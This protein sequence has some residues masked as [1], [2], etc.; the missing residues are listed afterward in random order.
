MNQ[1]LGSMMDFVMISIIIRL[2]TMMVE[3]AVDVL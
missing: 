2:A 3:T 1:V